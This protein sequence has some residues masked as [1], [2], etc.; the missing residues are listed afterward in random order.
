MEQNKLKIHSTDMQGAVNSNLPITVRLILRF[1][2]GELRKSTRHRYIPSSDR[3]TLSTRSWAGVDAVLKYALG[4]KAVGAD[5]SLAWPNWRPRTS[6]LRKQ[7]ETTYISLWMYKLVL[8]S[9]CAWG[10]NWATL[11]LGDINTEAWS[12]RMGVGREANNPTL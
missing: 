4:P 12:S 10:Y 11:P 8:N 7:K 1:L 2:V 3:A 6:K 5:H 9:N